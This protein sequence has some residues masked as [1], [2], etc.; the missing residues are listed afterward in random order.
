MNDKG[1]PEWDSEDTIAFRTFLKTRAGLRLVEKWLEAT[2]PL[3]AGGPTN[4]I[5]IRCG[6]SRGWSEAAQALL[7]LAF[8]APEIKSQPA[9]YPPLDDDSAWNDN[10]TKPTP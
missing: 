5:L 9:S 7:L 4:E 8:P 2:P 10:P 1:I 3:L 6:E